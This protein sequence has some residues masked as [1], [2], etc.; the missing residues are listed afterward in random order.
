MILSTDI[1]LALYNKLILTILRKHDVGRTFAGWFYRMKGFFVCNPL[2]GKYVV[3]LQE[4][5]KS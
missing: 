5:L 2:S 3:D 1:E 4:G